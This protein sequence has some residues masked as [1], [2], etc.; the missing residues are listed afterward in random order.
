LT[1]HRDLA[2]ATAYHRRRLV[3]AF[4]SGDRT[5]P[6]VEPPR[7]G[8]CLIG[9]LVLAAALVAV[10]AAS[11]ALTGHPSIG[12]HDVVTRIAR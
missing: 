11:Y 1:T 7:A 6:H 10:T 3:E 5:R 12:W 4:V 2:G 8:R 9:G